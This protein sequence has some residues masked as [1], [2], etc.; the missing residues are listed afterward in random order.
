MRLR[1][2]KPKQ[3]LIIKQTKQATNNKKTNKQGD[4]E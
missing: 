2:I 3:L 1:I 4:Y